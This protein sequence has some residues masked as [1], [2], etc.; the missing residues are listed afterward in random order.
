MNDPEDEDD[1][2]LDEDVVH[3]AVVTDAQ[4]VKGIPGAVQRLHGLALDPADL[5][6][7]PRELLERPSDPGANLGF[8]LPEGL[9]GCGSELDPI[10]VQVRSDRLTVRPWA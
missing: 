2:V 3:D 1:A 9:L 7:V 5:C 10:R 4:P 8:E 6:R